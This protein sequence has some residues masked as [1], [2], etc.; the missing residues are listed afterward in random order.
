[1][2]RIPVDANLDLALLEPRPAGM[3]F[4]VID[5][6]RAHLRRW[7]PWVDATRSPH[8]SA[9]FLHAT[10]GQFARGESL[11]VAILSH[12]ALAGGIGY[13]PIDWT[14]RRTSLGYWLAASFQGRGLM[15]RAVRAMT[16][17]AFASL[18]LHRL[19]IRAAVENQR[20]RN[21]AERA[22]FQLEGIARGNEW[23]HDRFVDHA[24]YSALATE[25]SP[26]PR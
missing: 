15:H 19:E 21:V 13:H 3:L 6:N 4:A 1:M 7:L 18:G 25:W 23:L 10:L 8:D 14:S 16:Q 17:H 2:F 12:G 24:V 26:S 22:G 11:S 9:A 5:E 20:S